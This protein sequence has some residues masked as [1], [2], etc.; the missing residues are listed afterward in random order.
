[1]NK[2]LILL[3]FNTLVFTQTKTNLEVFYS[4]LDTVVITA[5]GSAVSG[6]N[7][8]V[9]TYFFDAGEANPVFYNRAAN[10]MLTRN[11]KNVPVQDAQLVMIVDKTSVMYGE[12]FRDGFF[13]S[14][15][16][17]RNLYMHGNFLNKIENKSQDFNLVHSDTIAVDSLEY[18]E[19]QMYD[20]TKGNVPAEPFFS[21]LLEPTVAIVTTALAV[22]L[23]FAIRS[24]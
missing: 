19:S 13:G 3:L 4:L 8:D 18:V 16:I 2:L 7:S 15:Y 24:S 9:R 21:S 12:M 23:F 6:T 1:M 14:Y 17:P 10:E 11:Y 5:A 22:V 20:F